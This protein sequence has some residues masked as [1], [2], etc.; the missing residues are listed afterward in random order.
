[1]FRKF[2][3]VSVFI[4]IAIL[5][6]TSAQIRTH[7]QSGTALLR[8]VHFLKGV[9]KI[10]IYIDGNAVLTNLGFQDATTYVQFPEG[11]H[12][13]DFNVAGKG[14]PAGSPITLQ[15]AANDLFTFVFSGTIENKALD[16]YMTS[17]T[18]LAKQ[19]NLTLDNTTMPLLFVQGSK[20]VDAV[21]VYMN[22]KMVGSVKSGASLVALAPLTAYKVKVTA[23][24]DATKTLVETA[25]FGYADV[26]GVIGLTGPA[27]KLSLDAAYS[28]SI[29]AGQFFE[30]QKGTSGLTFNSLTNAVTAAKLADILSGP[31]TLTIFAPTDSAFAKVDAGQLNKLMAD[32]AAIENV[33]KYHVINDS[34]AFDDILNLAVAGG[35]KKTLQGTDLS[36]E[37]KGKQLTLGGT[38]ANLLSWNIHTSNAVIHVIDAVLMPAGQ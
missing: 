32:S 22:D 24:G 29:T 2:R 16:V 7:A 17:E 20:A 12:Q 34:V 11:T 1:M 23:A 15:A 3:F 27:E 35:S 21:D 25:I 10:D 18:G 30:A 6:A 31:G 4:V 37:L 26:V 36:V 28:T 38:A 19:A 9:P 8:A 14:Q 5:I 33:L 13:I